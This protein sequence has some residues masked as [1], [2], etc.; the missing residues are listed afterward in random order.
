M[1]LEHF[2]GV[3]IRLSLDVL[4]GSDQKLLQLVL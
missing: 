4:F 1:V 2:F 3:Q